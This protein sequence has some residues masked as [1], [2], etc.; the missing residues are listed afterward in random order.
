MKKSKVTYINSDA[1]YQNEMDYKWVVEKF[2][3][4]IWSSLHYLSEASTRYQLAGN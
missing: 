3:V 2:T 4:L 1:A